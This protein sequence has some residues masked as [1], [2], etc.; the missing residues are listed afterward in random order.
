MEQYAVSLV[1][2]VYR[3]K[4]W[5]R[6]ALQSALGQTMADM[7]LVIVNNDPSPEINAIIRRETKN[8]PNVTYQ[9]NEEN[10]GGAEAVNQGIRLA[11]GKYLFFM[12]SDDL[13][14]KDAVKILYEKAEETGSQMVIGRVKDII[15]GKVTEH[16]YHGDWVTWEREIAVEDVRQAPALAAAPFYWGRLYLRS[17]LLERD[18]FME[19]GLVNAD[20]LFTC[21]ALKAARG[22]AVSTRQVYFWRRF[23]GKAETRTVTQ[24]R[25]EQENFLDRLRMTRKVDAL[26]AEPG[27]EAL[28]SYVQLTGMARL[29]ILAKDAAEDEAFFPLYWREMSNYL[30]QIPLEAI[31][32]C[33][34]L[35]HRQKLLAYCIQRGEEQSFRRAALGQLHGKTTQRGGEIF[36]EYEGLQLPPGIDRQSC[37][38][39]KGFS[40]RCLWAGRGGLR[41]ELSVTPWEDCQPEFLAVYVMDW[42]RRERLRLPVLEE[43]RIG[44]GNIAFEIELGAA[45]RRSLGKGGLYYLSV[46]YL[47][48]GRV[49]RSRVM[50]KRGTLLLMNLLGKM[51]IH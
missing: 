26:F 48:D 7:E 11:R 46:A 42:R 25:A 43:R 5:L 34:Y 6:S 31:A 39:L 45:E 27:Y 35:T 47:V 13:L 37:F 40:A 32:G 9:R 41:L 22:I 10:V 33:V 17:F 21:K 16:K 8:R 38:Q 19:P 24:R 30:N 20:R 44:E 4:P 29:L 15:R 2:V 3:T 1:I 23:A 18:V 51:G 12:D 49:S 14:P 50:G 28:G 36:Y